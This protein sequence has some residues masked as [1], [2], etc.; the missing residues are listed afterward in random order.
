MTARAG[1]REGGAGT[2]RERI[3]TFLDHFVTDLA[4]AEAAGTL[5]L[6]HR[7]GS[8]RALAEGPATPEEFADA[9]P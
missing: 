9:P 5:A 3:N 7:P 2:D 6:G 1:R 8:G 4:S